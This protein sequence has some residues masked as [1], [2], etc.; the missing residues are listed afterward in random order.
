MSEIDKYLD[1]MDHTRGIRNQN[2]PE[3]WQMDGYRREWNQ[4][5]NEWVEDN[6]D[7]W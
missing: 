6:Y 1:W 5:M 3:I 2:R 4:Y 7:R